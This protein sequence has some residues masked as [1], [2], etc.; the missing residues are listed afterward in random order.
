M[1]MWGQR[2]LHVDKVISDILR[3]V[4]F[5]CC[6]CAIAHGGGSQCSLTTTWGLKS[7]SG[8]SKLGCQAPSSTE[9]AL[10]PQV[11]I[12]EFFLSRGASLPLTVLCSFC[13]TGCMYRLEMI[14]E[15]LLYGERLYQPC[16]CGLQ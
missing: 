7:S 2:L 14:T 4:T 3:V 13:E 5:I 11:S 9:L 16:L 8:L 12:P 1:Q 15:I 10:Q 6:V